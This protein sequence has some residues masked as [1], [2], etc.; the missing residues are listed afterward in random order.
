MNR[1]SIIDPP[2]G[3]IVGRPSAMN[4]LSVETDKPMPKSFALKQNYPNPFNPTTVIDYELPSASKVRVEL[5][6]VLGRK[7]MELFS[8]EKPAGYHQV[9]MNG[10]NLA[11][12]VYFYRLQAGTFVQTKKMLLVK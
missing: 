9:Q 12:G 10:L 2:A 6:D 1:V 8:G 7:V 5:Y 3:A 4:S 11:S